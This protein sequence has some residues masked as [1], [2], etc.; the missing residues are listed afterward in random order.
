M[1]AARRRPLPSSGRR[2]SPA[3]TSTSPRE[4]DLSRWVKLDSGRLPRTC[5]PGHC[6]VVQ[7]AG[8]G[9]IP[10]GFVRVGTG[11][12][13][14]QAPFGYL[15]EAR[16]RARSS[17]GRRAGTGRRRRRSS[18]R[19]VLRRRRGCPACSTT[20]EAIAGSSARAGRRPPVDSRSRHPEAGRGPRYGRRRLERVHRGRARPGPG[21]IP[22]HRPRRPA[23]PAA[24]RRGGG[25]SP[26]RVRGPGGLGAPTGCGGEPA[27]PH[28]AGSDPPADRTPIRCRGR[29]DRRRR[30]RGRLVC[31]DPSRAG[32]RES[33]RIARSRDRRALGP[34][35]SGLAV[36]ISLVVAT[37]AI[38]LA[39]VWAPQVQLGGFRFT[40]LDFAAVAA[41]VVVVFAFARGATDTSSLA[42]GKGTGAV[43]LL[44]P[45]LVV[46][47]A[48]VLAARAVGFVSRLLERAG[49]GG[50][51][52]L[53]LAA[54]SLARNP[55]RAA[56]AVSFLVVSLGLA[57]FAAVYRSTLTQA[58]R[59]QAA[60]AVPAAAIVGED[61]AKL[62]RVL[63]AAPLSQYQ[64]Y[65]P[66]AQVIRAERERPRRG[67]L[68]TARD[69]ER[70][71]RR[72]GWLALGL[73]VAVA[74]RARPADRA[75]G[76][77]AAAHCAA[78]GGTADAPAGRKRSRPRPRRDRDEG[79]GLPLRAAAREP[80][81]RPA[82]RL[83]L[84][85]HRPRP[86]ARGGHG[87]RGTSARKPDA[88]AAAASG[89][90]PAARGRL[91]CVE[92]QRPPRTPDP[93]LGAAAVP[94]YV[95]S[96]DRV[97]DPP[98]ARPRVGAGGVSS[99]IAAAAG[100]GRTSRFQIEG[101]PVLTRVVGTPT[102][103]LPST[104][105]SSSPTGRRSRPR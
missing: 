16:R 55:G 80:A 42:G 66:A 14:S 30:N 87:R 40:A 97:P 99:A 98:A 83:L 6:E 56:I 71:G 74:T 86:R 18:S 43:L 81:R 91:P 25:R 9:P 69:A 34:V 51:L 62:V 12:L 24:P 65:G 26:A 3:P 8:S 1:S 60:Y 101:T 79:W 17:R 10:R 73:L 44:L 85:R 84:R 72:R 96:P 92:G 28:L 38:L 105:T 70:H 5:A 104:A 77:G 58:Q 53:R 63:Q 21:V 19:R 57:V 50:P 95:R 59:D 11:S 88:E 68:H 64:R 13:V 23:A 103:S 31:R 41:A 102:A 61:D 67:K 93:R 7:L 54:L 39:S 82:T 4:D 75:R 90:R 47:I 20:T 32:G 35:R 36:A 27:P 33:L 94:R 52:P 78:P 49:R 46:F 89:E 45:G 15:V 2:G 76:A 22:R 37:A 100:P 48:A 29:R